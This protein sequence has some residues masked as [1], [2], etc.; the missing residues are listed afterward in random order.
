LAAA[1]RILDINRGVHFA[2]ILPGS[3]KVG[4]APVEPSF[5]AFCHTDCKEDLKALPGFQLVS[6]Y[7]SGKTFHENEYGACNGVRFILAP[8]YVPFADAGAA[9]TTMIST[10][11]T[12]A[13]VYPI[14][15]MAKNAFNAINFAGS[16]KEGFGNLQIFRQTEADKSDPTNARQQTAAAWYDLV[17]P[18]NQDWV[19]R[20]EVAVRKNPT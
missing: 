8:D 3:T 5:M 18:T 19:V 4:T 10:T 12:N 2:G 7:G 20:I 15:I 9:S 11:G 13:D 1:I 14:V 6:Q 16:G 17:M